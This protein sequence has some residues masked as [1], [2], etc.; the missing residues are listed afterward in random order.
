MSDSSFDKI[1]NDYFTNYHKDTVKEVKR[2]MPKL[3]LHDSTL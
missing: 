3:L 1:S 2:Q